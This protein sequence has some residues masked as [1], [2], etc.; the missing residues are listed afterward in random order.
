MAH[1]SLRNH[2]KVRTLIRLLKSDKLTIIGALQ[3]FW[4]AVDECKAVKP[5]GALEGWTE[6][7]ICDSAEWMGDPAEFTAALFKAGFIDIGDGA[8]F[9]HDYW[10]WCPNFVLK[11]WFDT[12]LIKDQSRQ[13]AFAASQSGLVATSYNKSQQVAP[14]VA[15]MVAPIVA[16]TTPNV[17]PRNVTKP[18]ETKPTSLPSP[19]APARVAKPRSEKQIERDELFEAVAREWYPS[20]VSKEDAALI[21]K[22]VTALKAKHATPSEIPVRRARWPTLYS[23]AGPLTPMGLAKHWDAL[24]AIKPETNGFVFDRA[25]FEAELRRHDELG[26]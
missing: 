14:I 15:P 19:E 20:G 2:R 22:A 12:G 4:W 26:I 8:Y 18:N 7:N 6:T 16:Y 1:S 25:G 3:H 9:V 11:R 13:T 24:G 21:G 23:D 17:T 10:E 5:N